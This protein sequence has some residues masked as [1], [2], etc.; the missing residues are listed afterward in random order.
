MLAV[1][2]FRA[3][4]LHQLRVGRRLNPCIVRKLSTDKK[5]NKSTNFAE[6]NTTVAYYLA[7]VATLLFG[8][9]YA[10][11]P[12]YKVFCQMTGESDTLTDIEEIDLD[13]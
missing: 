12:L 8:L 11:V 6:S 4:T 7:G 1:R 5:S 3:S 10:S 2:S 13:L 9:S